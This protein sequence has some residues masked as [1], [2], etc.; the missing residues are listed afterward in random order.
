[1]ENNNEIIKDTHNKYT[2]AYIEI[3]NTYREQISLAVKQKND[4]KEHFFKTIKRIIY[5]LSCFFVVTLTLSFVIFGIMIYKNYNSVSVIAGA[6]TT[7]ISSFVTMI[8]AI[9][10]LP[11]II[12][13]YL[14]NKQEDKLM[15]EV[16]KN[17]QIYEID[18]EYS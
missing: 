8:I 1:M 17:I 3:L 15:N 18:A 10:K 2:D 4:L 6:V 16:I 11:E 5:L 9:Y 14:F 13:E 12:A 7:V